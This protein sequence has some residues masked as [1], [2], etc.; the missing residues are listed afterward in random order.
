MGKTIDKRTRFDFIRYANC[1]EDADIL[2]KA[3][4]PLKNAKCLS[5]ASSGDN[6]LALLA[7]EPS[8]V[9]T[10]DLSSVQLACV[11]LRKIVFRYLSYEKMLW[12]L[13]F[14]SQIEGTVHKTRLAVYNTLRS[15]LSDISREFWDKNPLLVKKGIIHAGKVERYFKIFRDNVLPFVHS[16]K[17]IK[18]LLLK[19][20][21]TSRKKFYE[22]KWNTFLFN[23]LFKLFFSRL[24]MG[25]MGRDPEFFRYVEGS[26]ADR[27]L[28]RTRHGLTELS[29]HDNPYLTFILTGSFENS[30]PL[31]ARKKHF[32]TIR[33]N[34]DNLELFQGTVDEAFTKYGISFN[35]FNLS[36][37]FEYMDHKTFINAAKN[38]LSHAQ[39]QSRIAY[40]NMLVPRSISESFPQK[41]NLLTNLSNK[42][43]FEDKT[44]FYQSFY[45]DKVVA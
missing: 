42:L 44:F 41:A 3:L 23:M 5:I 14:Q 35:A 12:F 32:E 6:S 43:A 39:P 40:W 19:K 21:Y 24:I 8:L 37:I 34:L 26:V 27:I 29:T 36:D 25:I 18:T 33:N 16:K 13:G 28:E 2:V 1:W 17:T 4:F 15:E 10:V 45:I 30:L 22:K 7:F 11:E 9:L 38:I 20:D 31:Y